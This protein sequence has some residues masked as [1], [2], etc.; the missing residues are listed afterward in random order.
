MKTRQGFVSNS[1]SSS[2]IVIGR[3]TDEQL[4]QQ[5]KSHFVEDEIVL[6]VASGNFEFGWENEKYSD[7]WSKANFAYLQA[8]YA[9]NKKWIKMIEK[10]IKDTLKVSKIT[11]QLTIDYPDNNNGYI[12]H[13]SSSSEDMNIGMFE[14][15][16][17][18][19]LFLFSKDSYIQTGND[20]E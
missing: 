15:E 10:V 12:D 6:G 5:L 8:L 4:I 13:Q 17:E 11:W 3:T 1:S 18:L 7:F 9:Q 19:K 16:E 14:S 2:F 20:N